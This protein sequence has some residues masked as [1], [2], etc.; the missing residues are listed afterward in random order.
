MHNILIIGAGRSSSSLIQYVLEHSEQY[1]WFVVV[2]DQDPALAA[3]QVGNHPRGRAVWLDASKPQDRKELINRADVVVSLLPAHLHIVV[4]EDCV[5]LRKHLITASYVSQ[6]LWR[7]G[8]MARERD[9]I[10]MGEMGLDPGIDHMAAVRDIHEIKEMG[11]KLHTFHSF[12]GGLVDLKHKPNPWKYKFTWNPRN[13]IL[14]GQGTAQ[15]LKDGKNRFIPYNRLFKTFKVVDIP[16]FGS[17]EAYA[18]RD[19]LLYQEV[20]GLSETANIQ[21]GTLRYP[22]FC[23]AWSAL[24]DLGLTDDSFPIINSED[25]TYHN[26]MEAYINPDDKGTVKEKVAANLG[27]PVDHETIKK[28]EWLG[29]FRKIKIGIQHASPAKILEHLLLEKWAMEPKDR[30]LVVMYHE[31]RYKL[32]GKEYTRKST[33]KLMGTSDETAMAKLVGLPLAIFVKLVMLGKIKARGGNI[34]VSRDVYEPVLN[35]L[36]DYGIKFEMEIEEH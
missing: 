9:L 21:R 15:Y 32:K 35:E 23:D 20:Y 26:L 14:A 16:G 10:F 1:H 33:M 34:P 6:E 27:I 12:A 24:V 2:A 13:V 17:M 25:M 11:G 31:Y 4:A 36:G 22:G 5:Q 29:L 3:K 18:N 28:L 30:D 19:S 7:L 8:E